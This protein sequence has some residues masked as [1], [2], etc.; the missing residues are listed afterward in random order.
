MPM[1]THRLYKS[2]RTAIPA[3]LASLAGLTIAAQANAAAIRVV[4]PG[5]QN[6]KSGEYECTTGTCTGTWPYYPDLLKTELGAGYAVEND[7]D[8]GAILGCDAATATAAGGN[9]ICAAGGNYSKSVATAP[10]IVIIGP[11]GEHDQRIITT[12]QADMALYDEPTFEA[13]YEGLVSKYLAYTS[14]VYLMTPIDVPF[15]APALST[16]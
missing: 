11:F 3:A 13:V 1:P 2:F 7:G 15:N 16:G 5:E 12:N 10:D 4:T 6:T 8:G 14:R 9:S